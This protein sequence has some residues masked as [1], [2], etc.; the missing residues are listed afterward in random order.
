MKLIQRHFAGSKHAG[1]LRSCGLIPATLRLAGGRTLLT[2]IPRSQLRRL[3]YRQSHIFTVNGAKVIALP[4]RWHLDP[5]SREVRHLEYETINQQI[6]QCEVP[7]L[8]VNSADVASHVKPN[9]SPLTLVA[10]VS[11]VPNYVKVDTFGFGEGETPTFKALSVSN[12]RSV[13]PSTVSLLAPKRGR[14]ALRS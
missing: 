4:T 6:V 14:Q 10:G 13:A 3:S 5:L 11:L 7:V 1:R 8:C 2:A 12:L 9:A